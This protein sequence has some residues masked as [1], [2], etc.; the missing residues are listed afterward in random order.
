[1]G[2]TI[3]LDA[4]VRCCRPLHQE[5]RLVM[6]GSDLRGRGEG[7]RGRRFSIALLSCIVCMKQQQQ[8]AGSS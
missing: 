7:Q 1:M 6:K 4:Q 8:K 2:R 3:G 5:G